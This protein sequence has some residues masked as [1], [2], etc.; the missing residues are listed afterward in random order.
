MGA[1]VIAAEGRIE[2]VG[3][4]DRQALVYFAA[5]GPQINVTI[6]ADPSV[7][8]TSHQIFKNV[9]SEGWYWLE[10][11]RL[12]RAKLLDQSVFKDLLRGVADFYEL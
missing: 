6:G 3:S 10:D 11:V 8:H 4:R 5:G 9:T 7:T 12:G 2:I 1:A